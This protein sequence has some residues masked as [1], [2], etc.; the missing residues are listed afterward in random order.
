MGGWVVAKLTVDHPELVDRLVLYDSAGIYFPAT[1][2]ASLFSPSDKAGLEHLTHM[3]E[4][5]P[6]K[7]PDFAVRAAIRKLQRNAWVIQRS[8][9]AMT[10]GRDLLDF[11]LAHI[12][13]P[14]LIVWGDKD[15]LIPVSVAESM[16]QLIPRSSLVFV[17]GCGHLA[18]AQCS[19]PVIATTVKFLDSEPPWSN[20]EQTLPGH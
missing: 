14:T 16:H 9:S 17:Q 2:D 4:P 1:F 10:S 11:R 3:L 12:S 20:V 18:P 19:A 6:P 8:V 5:D 15:I 7:L 13:R